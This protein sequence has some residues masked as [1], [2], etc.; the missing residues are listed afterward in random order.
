MTSSNFFIFIFIE[1]MFCTCKFRQAS[2]RQLKSSNLLF[3]ILFSSNTAF[4]FITSIY[5]SPIKKKRK[6]G[7][8]RQQECVIAQGNILGWAFLGEVSLVEK[9]NLYCVIEEETSFNLIPILIVLRF[10]LARLNQQRRTN[11]VQ[12]NQY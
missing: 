4:A 9:F 7:E 3:I 10:K 2:H 8:T 5:L 6:K 11:K 12:K 1:T